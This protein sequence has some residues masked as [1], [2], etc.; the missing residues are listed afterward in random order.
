MS[1]EPSFTIFFTISLMFDATCGSM[2]HPFSSCNSK[3]HMT[4]FLWPKWCF[5]MDRPSSYFL[6]PLDEEYKDG[7]RVDYRYNRRTRLL[8]LLFFSRFFLLG[9]KQSA[10]QLYA[11]KLQLPQ[12]FVLK[13]I[14]LSRERV[15]HGF[16]ATAVALFQI[17][18]QTVLDLGERRKREEEKTQFTFRTIS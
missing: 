13:M 16:F 5:N 4:I 7:L 10:V 17:G 15:L 11:K 2:F 14:L 6:I 9:I 1:G 8:C 18:L 3:G 12:N